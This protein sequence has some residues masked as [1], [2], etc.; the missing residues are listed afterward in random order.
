MLPF[1][2]FFLVNVDLSD[3]AVGVQ[4][5]APAKD[6]EANVALL[7]YMSSVSIFYVP[8]VCLSWTC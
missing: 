1:L 2:L 8:T 4:I 5:D 7:E 3:E 6:G